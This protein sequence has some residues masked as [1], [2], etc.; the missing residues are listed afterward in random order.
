MRYDLRSAYVQYARSLASSAR[1][2]APAAQCIIYI[3]VIDQRR[4]I[5]GNNAPA[6]TDT[7]SDAV[8]GSNSSVAAGS[9]SRYW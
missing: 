5:C 6:T 4:A 8:V 7:D 2:G 9:W 1:R 3:L